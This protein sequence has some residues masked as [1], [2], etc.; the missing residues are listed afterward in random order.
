M[1]SGTLK[2]LNCNLS[3]TKNG[4]FP[5]L[6][7]AY[8]LLAEFI[9]R[10]FLTIYNLKPIVLKWLLYCR[11]RISFGIFGIFGESF[12]HRLCASIRITSKEREIS[13]LTDERH[14]TVN[15]ENLSRLWSIRLDA[16]NRTLKTTTQIWV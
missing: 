8:S 1:P 7:W 10:L 15:A 5:A 16:A 11:H 6:S 4:N 13:V 9:W 12:T 2:P 14:S 3:H